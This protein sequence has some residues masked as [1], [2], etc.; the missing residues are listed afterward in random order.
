MHS[1]SSGSVFWY[2][3]RRDACLPRPSAFICYVFTFYFRFAD[4]HS[5]LRDLQQMGTNRPRLWYNQTVA[6]RRRGWRTALRTG[7]PKRTCLICRGALEATIAPTL[8]LMRKIFIKS[9]VCPCLIFSPY[10]YYDF[11]DNVTSA[12]LGENNDRG[13]CI[14]IWTG[15]FEHGKIKIVL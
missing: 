15:T 1:L 7:S 10:A 9:S 3:H 4:Q 6:Q 14:I 12:P 2:S 11:S 8:C 5:V 13:A